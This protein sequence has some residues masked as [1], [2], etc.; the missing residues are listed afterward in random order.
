MSAIDVANQWMAA[1]QSG[2]FQGAAS[3]LSDD[4]IFEG[5]VPQPVGKAEFTGLMAALVAGI[6]DWNFNPSDMSEQGDDVYV[7]NN[8]TGT[9]TGTL[10]LPMLPGPIA[11][12][13]KS[14]SLP[15]E[16][17][18]ITVRNGQITHI[19]VESNP[20]GGVMGILAQIGVQ[21]PSM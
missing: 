7:T 19:N 3:L 17:S 9:H 13:G 5:P 2:D 12:T 1:S 21:M 10:N 18:V 15:A 4:M 8:I 6:P 16:P 20:Q 11:P 14:I